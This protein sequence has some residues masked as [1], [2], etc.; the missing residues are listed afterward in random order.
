MLATEI[1]VLR[2]SLDEDSTPSEKHLSPSQPAK[3]LATSKEQVPLAIEKYGRRKWEAS[4]SALFEAPPLS[5]P[6]E[7]KAINR[8]F[9]KMRE[10]LLSCCIRCNEASYRIGEA[11]GGFIQAVSLTAPPTWTAVSLESEGSPSPRLDLLPTEKGRFL[12]DLPFQGDVLRE[13]CRQKVVSS[14]GEEERVDLVTA[15]GACE[16]D[17]N[18]LETQHMPL[19]LAQTDLAMNLLSKGGTFVCKFFEASEYDT[20]LWIAGTT[21][22][23]SEVSVIK[24]MWSRPTNSE[25]YLVCKG[26]EG[27][28][29]PLPR[30]A[31]LAEGWF[32][33]T[34]GVLDNLTSKQKKSI[35]RVL[36][37][38]SSHRNRT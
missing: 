19:L 7:L 34:R 8:A 33:R 13:E 32:E 6:P 21:T 17:H 37:Y 20:L 3:E 14:K 35:D 38:L 24:P 23:F 22:R 12:T 4:I 11:P 1:T 27:G 15:D 25:R 26:F 16:M 10:I 9:H 36:S 29:T 30:S 2:C 18:D 5:L 28:A 31:R